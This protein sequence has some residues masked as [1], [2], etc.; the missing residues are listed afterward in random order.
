MSRAPIR[1]W[2]RDVMVSPAL[3]DQSLVERLES[4]ATFDYDRRASNAITARASKGN[5]K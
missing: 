4:P 3:L 1:I 5:A 2:D